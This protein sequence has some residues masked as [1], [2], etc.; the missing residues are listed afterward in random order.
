MGATAYQWK[1]PN[2]TTVTTSAPQ[3]VIPSIDAQHAG[4]YQVVAQGLTCAA[5]T[6]T[7]NYNVRILEKPAN[8][9]TYTFCAAA[10]VAELKAKV[11]TDTATVRVYKNG[12]LVTNNNE[13]LTTTDAYTVS[14][15]NATCETDKVAVTITISNTVSLTVPTTL[16]VTCTVANID[17]TVNNRS[18]L[19]SP[20][21]PRRWGN[22][23]IRPD[24]PRSHALAHPAS[25]D[26]EIGR[27][28]CRERV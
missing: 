12:T 18:R 24:C 21:W 14:R 27:A 1:Y 3:L 8:G 2:G 20:R 4:I 7:F 9:K 11:A 25:A 10:T 6:V 19:P 23:P 17:V 5:N 22:R 15:F 26:Y 13:T 16:T 28:S